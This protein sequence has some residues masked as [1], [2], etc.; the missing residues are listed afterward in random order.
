MG[1]CVSHLWNTQKLTYFM[2]KMFDL[3]AQ[4]KLKLGQKCRTKNDSLQS[5]LLQALCCICPGTVLQ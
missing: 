2:V 3:V 1:I 5:H 4:T